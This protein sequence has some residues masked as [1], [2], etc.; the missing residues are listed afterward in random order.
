[1]AAVEGFYGHLERVLLELGFLDPDNPRHLMRRL[2]RLFGRVELTESE[3][4]VLRG[5]LAAAEGRKLP[6]R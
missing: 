3:V 5:V 6:R 1:V 2:R 4:A